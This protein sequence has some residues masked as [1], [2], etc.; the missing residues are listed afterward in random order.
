MSATRPRTLAEDLRTRDDAALAALLRA[1][2]DLLSPIP[3]DLTSLAARATTRPSTQRAID[4]LD[5]F[6]LQV[7]EAVCA[8]PEPVTAADLR[9]AVVADPGAAVTDLLDQ[10]LVF[11]AGEANGDGY[12][13]LM[14]PRTVREVIGAPAGLGPPLDQALL[15][16]GPRRLETLAADIGGPPREVLADPARL[17]A[18]LATAAPGAHEALQ[19]LVW[20][21]PTGRLDNAL[22]EVSAATAATPVEWLLAHGLLV[23]GD[24]RTVVLPR[25]VA[26]HLRAGRVHPEVQPTLP[27]HIT[28][29]ADARRVDSTAAGEAAT[30]VR[31][32]EE[33]LDLWADLPPRVLRAGGLGVRDRARTATALDVSEDVMTLIVEVAHAAGLV[34]AGDDGLDEA[35]LPTQTYDDWLD[36]PT[37]ERW[38]FLVDAWRRSTRA[39]GLAG[40]KDQRGRALAPLGP[41]LDRTLAPVVRAAVLA[42]LAGLAPGQ[43]TTADSLSERLR[44]RAPRRGG[45]LQDDL[46]RWTVRE[47]GVLGLTAGGALA[48]HARRLVDGDPDAAIAA[49]DK[50]L[51]P[52]LD[53]VLLQADLTAV[54]PGPLRTDLARSLRLVADVE[55]TGGATV[56]RFTEG[57]VRRAFDAGWTAVDVTDLLASTSRTP[58]PQP[59]AYLVDDVARRHGRMRV[60]AAAAFVRADDESVLTELLSDKRASALRLRRLAP[61]VLSAQSAPEVVLERL[62]EMG[63]APAAEGTDGAVVVRRPESRRTSARPPATITSVGPPP[64]APALLAAAVTALRAGDRAS[65]VTLSR[66]AADMLAILG[67][68]AAAGESL[69]IGY[70][71]AEGR[72]TQRVIDPVA[73]EG[74]QVSAYDHLRGAMRSFAVHRITGVSPV[75]DETAS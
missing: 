46:V 2:P 62:R 12:A 45:R 63:Y 15:G 59:L 8:L 58:V 30:V 16:Y 70:V 65:T 33:L 17:D 47:A 1:R 43:A 69:W 38:V 6:T 24:V 3:S 32:L 51:P 53:H 61:T 40:G 55:S 52:L 19:S 28:G 35:W 73:V 4:L 44:W 7:L 25:E 13:G 72:G 21:P 75:S 39:A 10:A 29:P 20:G 54:A 68:A 49:L 56:Y 37:A 14:V 5:R 71:D 48:T 23:A 67:D 64:P 60:G 74:G 66:P 18:L 36:A 41:D 34:A 11:R 26:L 9:A 31:Q 42:D 57:S 50:A 22:R 27:E